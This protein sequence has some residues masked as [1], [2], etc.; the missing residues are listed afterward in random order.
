MVLVAQDLQ[1]EK[2]AREED[3]ET[4]DAPLYFR[5]MKTGAGLLTKIR[6]IL[7]GV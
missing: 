1:L 4:C 5:I 2:T 6:L 3:V 7:H